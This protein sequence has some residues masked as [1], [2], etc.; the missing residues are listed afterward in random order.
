V[1]DDR[2]RIVVVCTGN[3]FR[4]P[5]V[6]TV[7]RRELAGLPVEISS[8]GTLE[9]GPLPT[10]VEALR[11]G[12]DLGLQ[13]AR[14]RA[15]SMGFGELADA[16]LVLGFERAH[17]LAAI[18]HGLASPAVVFTLPELA[19]RLQRV[20]APRADNAVRSWRALVAVAAE[21]R[22]AEIPKRVPEIDD[23]IGKP[24][25]VSNEIA[26]CV[27]ELAAKVA[28]ELRELA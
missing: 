7:L 1:T 23:P 27:V 10:L 9:V 26:L 5:I 21:S 3:R 20:H 12:R 13:L 11:V 19:R 16:D 25:A 15:R 14:H 28:A 6:E 22:G 24:A 2:F 17:L 4:S 8:R 18:A